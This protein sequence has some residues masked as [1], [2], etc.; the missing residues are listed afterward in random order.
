MTDTL[1]TDPKRYPAFYV[2]VGMTDEPSALEKK[3]R[4]HSDGGERR[5]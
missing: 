3:L 2:T 4:P 1:L 5:R